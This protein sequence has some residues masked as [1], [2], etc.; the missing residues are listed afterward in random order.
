MYLSG[1]GHLIHNNQHSHT[2]G[3]V[4]SSA[5]DATIG[6]KMFIIKFDREQTPIL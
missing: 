3:I 2:D 1:Q 5:K 6:V 4:N